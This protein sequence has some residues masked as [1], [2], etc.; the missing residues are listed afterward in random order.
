MPGKRKACLSPTLRRRD[1]VVLGS[2]LLRK[3]PSLTPL[4]T[5][6]NVRDVPFAAHMYNWPEPERRRSKEPLIKSDLAFAPRAPIVIIRVGHSGVISFRLSS[7][8]F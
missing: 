1:Y 4:G 6:C 3:A 5:A 7:H 2:L 8:V